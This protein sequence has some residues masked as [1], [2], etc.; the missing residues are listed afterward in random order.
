MY[1]FVELPSRYPII[2]NMR[3]TEI[4]KFPHSVQITNNS[5]PYHGATRNWTNSKT[6]VVPRKYQR[7]AGRQEGRK[8][9]NRIE[10][11]RITIQWNLCA[12]ERL[13]DGLMDS[14]IDSFIHLFA[15][16]PDSGLCIDASVYRCIDPSIHLDRV[17]H[18]LQQQLEIG[19]VGFEGVVVKH[20][21][22]RPQPPQ[23]VVGAS[24]KPVSPHNAFLGTVDLGANNTGIAGVVPQA[25]DAF[26]DHELR[27]LL[28]LKRARV[29]MAVVAAVVAAVVVAVVA[30]AVVAAAA[31][32]A[33][34]GFVLPEPAPLPRREPKRGNG[35]P[36][37][38]VPAKVMEPAALCVL[39]EPA[40]DNQVGGRPPRDAVVV[41]DHKGDAGCCCCC[42]CCC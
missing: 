23:D 30:A 33:L 20:A 11:N 19:L 2:M 35:T 26:G 14:F 34:G 29:G 38:V 8:Q 36:G 7:Q 16:P 28:P 25:H 31:A 37:L 22:V 10:S 17:G 1:K 27:K 13:V 18:L 41:V 4:Q 12:V 24:R 42:C 39:G 40:Q 5:T 9:L 15:F 3:S 32:A 21:A 6:M